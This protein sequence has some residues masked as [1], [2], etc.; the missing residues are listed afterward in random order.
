MPE[1]TNDERGRRVFQI[2]KEKAAE[3]AIEKIRQSMG[4]DWKIFTSTDLG[5]LRYILEETW[6]SL[7][8]DTWEK[9]AFSRMKKSQLDSVI[10]IGGRVKRE[11]VREDRGVEEVSRIL[12]TLV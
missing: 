11:E 8:R 12:L 9:C 6:V 3:A 1:V 5:I 4:P 2:H 7:D 10:R